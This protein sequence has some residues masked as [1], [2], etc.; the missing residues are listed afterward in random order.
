MQLLGILF[1]ERRTYIVFSGKALKNFVQSPPKTFTVEVLILNM[2]TIEGS[3]FGLLL[4]KATYLDSALSYSMT[5]Q[6]FNV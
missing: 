1:V 5:S 3:S 4:L 6:Q 2:S